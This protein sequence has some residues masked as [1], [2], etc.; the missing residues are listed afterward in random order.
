MILGKL[1][2]PAK[3][4]GVGRGMETQRGGGRSCKSLEATSEQKLRDRE[5]VNR[6]CRGGKRDK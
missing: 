1:I 6:S 3:H 5:D 4:G 2:D